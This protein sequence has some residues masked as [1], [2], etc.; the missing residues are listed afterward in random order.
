MELQLKELDLIHYLLRDSALKKI[1]ALAVSTSYIASNPLIYLRYI[2][3][4]SNTM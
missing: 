2:R 1:K 3:K 4:Q